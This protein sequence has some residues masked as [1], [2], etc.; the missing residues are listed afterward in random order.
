MPTKS[1][2][3]GKCPSW[4]SLGDDTILRN[5]YRCDETL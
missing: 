1:L 3:I 2:L 4:F 5:D